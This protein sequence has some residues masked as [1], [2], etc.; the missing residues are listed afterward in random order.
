MVCSAAGGSW[1]GVVQNGYGVNLMDAVSIGL[2]IALVFMV[3][4]AIRGM[5]G[6]NYQLG[7]DE[8]QPEPAKEEPKGPTED[9]WLDLIRYNIQTIHS[10]ICAIQTKLV[11]IEN[12]VAQ[13]ADDLEPLRRKLHEVAQKVDHVAGHFAFVPTAEILED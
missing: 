11:S 2:G 6:D 7:E 9:D 12:E 10:N 8:R 5:V 3:W 13:N 4:L 1:S